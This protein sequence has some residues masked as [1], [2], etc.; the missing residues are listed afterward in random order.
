MIKWWVSYRE[1]SWRTE[2]GEDVNFDNALDLIW[3]RVRR[4]ECRIIRH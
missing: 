4:P 1:K 2:A 3:F